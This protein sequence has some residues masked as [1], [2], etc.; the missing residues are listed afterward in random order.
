MNLSR[1]ALTTFVVLA[2]LSLFACSPHHSEADT[3]ARMDAF[4][5]QQAAEF[6]GVYAQFVRNCGD[7]DLVTG[8]S[9]YVVNMTPDKKGEAGYRM[10]YYPYMHYKW[11]KKPLMTDGLPSRVWVVKRLLNL[12]FYGPGRYDSVLMVKLVDEKY[13]PTGDDS[14]G[15]A[16]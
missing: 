5:K 4:N 2:C 15:D 10:A 7:A 9:C 1:L 6:R 14:D 3:Q 8:M 16:P 13:K 11:G 12:T